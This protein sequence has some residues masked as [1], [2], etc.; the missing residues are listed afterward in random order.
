MFI[1]QV[2]P[3]LVPREQDLFAANSAFM[4]YFIFVGHPH[5]D[6]L[7]LFER[8][9]M[10][11]LEVVNVRFILALAPGLSDYIVVSMPLS[12]TVPTHEEKWTGNPQKT[13]VPKEH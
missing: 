11:F 6:P 5:V 12:W 8:H 4:Q 10:R 7:E 3:D 13:P 1:A 2:V 9:S